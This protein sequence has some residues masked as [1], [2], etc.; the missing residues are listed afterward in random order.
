MKCSSSP[1]PPAVVT[2]GDPGTPSNGQRQL[3]GQ[4]F[5][6][7]VTYTCDEGYEL[8]GS[9]RRTCEARGEWS[10]E[11]PQCKSTYVS[12]VTLTRAHAHVRIYVC[13]CTHTHTHTY[14]HTHTFTHTY[15]H[16]RTHGLIALIHIC[17]HICYQ[18]IHSKYLFT[19]FISRLHCQYVYHVSLF[20]CGL[21]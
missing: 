13:K 7:E 14:I 11:L 21:R 19:Y 1:T 2:C 16:I 12:Y 17:L 20:S 10:G 18:C 6:T 8:E 3:S 5:G 4:N 15:T 9:R